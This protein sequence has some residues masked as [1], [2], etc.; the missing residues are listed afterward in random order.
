VKLTTETGPQPGIHLHSGLL[1]GVKRQVGTRM[2]HRSDAQQIVHL[3]A[4]AA[5]ARHVAEPQQLLH[6]AEQAL[7]ASVQL[8]AHQCLLL[9][10]LH[11]VFAGIHVLALSLTFAASLPMQV[12]C[13]VDAK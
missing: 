7:R 13:A 9:S 8:H 6:G 4:L 3:A 12:R 2:H 5:A 11:S 10:C 1:G